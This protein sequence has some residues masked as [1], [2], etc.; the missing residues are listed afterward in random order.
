MVRIVADSTCD[1][2]G[3]I[4]RD[5]G[6]SIVPLHI[7]LGEAE[8]RD[9]VDIHPD[10]IFKW[11]EENKTTPKTSAVSFED[12]LDDLSPIAK[13]GDEAVIFVISET[14]STTGNVFRM[15]IEELEA[16]DRMFVF[17]SKNLSV[18]IGLLAM[19]ASEMAKAGVDAKEML[20][21][22]E[23]LR[24][25]VRSSF[26]VDT[27]TYL[28]RGGRCSA[29]TA[30]AGGMFKIHPKIVVKDGVMEAEKRYRGQM[31]SVVTDYVNDLKDELL[32]AKSNRAFLV[33]SGLEN[34]ISDQAMEFL[35]GL[36]HFDEIISLN[37]GGVIS[38]H[39]GPGT[40]G[41]MYIAK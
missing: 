6:I 1:L 4:A 14:M 26:V 16:E 7:V 3:D 34:E 11:C 5:Y 41:V 33:Y 21:K 40:L 29:A 19:E 35:K 38:S 2:S 9:G 17:D 25:K 18:G 39:C 13:S 36:D 24:D 32:T 10:D 27:L 37:A 8:Y 31:H 23:E 12:V 15:A 22:L 20:C 28:A 30:L